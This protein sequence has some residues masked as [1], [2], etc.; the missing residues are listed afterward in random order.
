MPRGVRALVVVTLVAILPEPMVAQDGG[1]EAGGPEV[2]GVVVERESGRPLA[3][4]TVRLAPE[5][6]G[7]EIVRITDRDGRFRFPGMAPAAYRLHLTMIGYETLERPVELLAGLDVSIR[8]ELVPDALELEPIF[9]VQTRR[10]PPGMHAFEERR[11]MGFGTFFTRDDIEYHNPVRLTDLLQRVPGVRTQSMSGRWG[12]E[13]FM[14]GNCRPL[15]ILDGMRVLNIDEYGGLDEL[16]LPHQVEAVEVYR[17]VA[18]PVE[19]GNT[20]CGVVAVWTR[21]SEPGR[22]WSWWRAAAAAVLA[23]GIYQVAW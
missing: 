18:I 3:S 7:V 14:T 20:S 13:V 11:R 21:R 6:E 15:F 10:I 22:P 8:V 1:I 5:G 17:G 23:F 12:N 9:V 2:T 19:F 4:V 16:I